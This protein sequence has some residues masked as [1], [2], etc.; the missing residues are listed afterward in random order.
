MSL[1]GD[2]NVQGEVQFV[3]SQVARSQ[4]DDAGA[5]MEDSGVCSVLSDRSAGGVGETWYVSCRLQRL[6]PRCVVPLL[7]VCV[8][9]GS[10][11]SSRGVALPCVPR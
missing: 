8:L 9:K 11:F 2:N 4:F 3:P 10:A 1:S 5:S 6:M 7:S